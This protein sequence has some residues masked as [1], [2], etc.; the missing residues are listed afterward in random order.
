MKLR[1]AKSK[2]EKWPFQKT[3]TR[4]RTLLL[5]NSSESSNVALDR[6]YRKFRTTFLEVGKMQTKMLMALFLLVV[7]GC[8]SSATQG[9]TTHHVDADNQNVGDGS[10]TN[11]FQT[12]EKGLE[13]TTQT[14][15]VLVH[16]VD[17]LVYGSAGVPVKWGHYLISDSITIEAGETLVLE[18]GV[19]IKL[20]YYTNAAKNPSI[21]VNG[22]LRALGQAGGG[23]NSV[24][25]TSERDNT[26]GESSYQGHAPEP[27]DWYHIVFNDSSDDANC[28]IEHAEIRYAGQYWWNSFGWHSRSE[29]AILM[30]SASPTIRETST[31]H[32][33][34]YPVEMNL[35][36]FPKMRGLKAQ[37]RD[38]EDISAV[39][40]VGGTM[41]GGGTWSNPGIPYCL[42]DSVTV[43]SGE[44]LVIDPGTIVKFKV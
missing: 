12:I 41:A 20:K 31:F 6:E 18:P 34:G 26:V 21:I 17:G 8:A 28:L 3:V 2:P 25:F 42:D 4:S 38:G 22:C 14:D 33:W 10:A 16:K 29:E 5:T 39:H 24:Y 1:I 40:I 36:S 11:P 43:A 9:A 32:C 7:L 44:T 35:D 27:G 30:T 37:G 23:E 13:A 19:V 15:K